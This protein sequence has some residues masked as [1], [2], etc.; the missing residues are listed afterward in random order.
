MSNKIY[1]KE[2][3]EKYKIKYNDNIFYRDEVSSEEISSC[4]TIIIAD[5]EHQANP[6]SNL[7]KLSQIANDDA[8]III[9]SKNMFLIYNKDFKIF[10]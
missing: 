4:N 3:D 5:I 9:L 6:T 7:L 1:V 2:I 8:K 10:F